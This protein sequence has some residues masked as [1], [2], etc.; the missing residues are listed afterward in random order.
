MARLL[1][2]ARLHVYHGG[3]IALIT[4]APQLAPVVEEFLDEG[5]APT[6]TPRTARAGR[7]GSR[8]TS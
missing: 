7:S 1:P 4:E 2:D 8:P 3:H 5:T 6:S